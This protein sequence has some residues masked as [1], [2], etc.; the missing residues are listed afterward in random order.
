MLSDSAHVL[1]NAELYLTVIKLISYCIC[2][3]H[4]HCCFLRNGLSYDR[5]VGQ[6][7]GKTWLCSSLWRSDL[8]GSLC[9]LLIDA[10]D[11]LT[12]SSYCTLR[13]DRTIALICST[14]CWNRNVTTGWISFCNDP[15]A[16]VFYCRGATS[17][18]C[19]SFPVCASLS[20]PAAPITSTIGSDQAGG[21]ACPAE[22]KSSACRLRGMY[23]TAALPSPSPTTWLTVLPH[24]PSLLTCSPH[25]SLLRFFSYVTD[26]SA[27]TAWRSIAKIAPN[28]SWNAHFAKLT[29]HLD[30]VSIIVNPKWWPPLA[31]WTVVSSKLQSS[32]SSSLSRVVS[33]HANHFR[34]EIIAGETNPIQPS[35]KVEGAISEEQ[36]LNTECLK[37][38]MAWMVL[39]LD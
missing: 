25:P 22:P 31:S 5:P 16:R 36:G 13:W 29:R 4:F 18:P 21:L 8:S 9:C 14:A 19:A 38:S 15:S 28:N 24:L 35:S 26:I 7:K 27:A 12:C 17:H 20:C 30:N 1:N 10:A 33:N 39:K 6:M 34:Y 11:A 23:S 2:Q 3:D 32:L 37:Y